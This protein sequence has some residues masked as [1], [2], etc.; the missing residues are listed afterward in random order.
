MF[1]KTCKKT[2]DIRNM[3]ISVCNYA[4]KTNKISTN[5]CRPLPPQVTPQ[6]PRDFRCTIKAN[7][8]IQDFTKLVKRQKK[9]NQKHDHL[10]VPLVF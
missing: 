5:G 8:Y 2:T 4:F 1:H 9:D 7:V 3:T 10:N 6:T